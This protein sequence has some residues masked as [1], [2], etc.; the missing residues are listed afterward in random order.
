MVKVL[1]PTLANTVGLTYGIGDKEGFFGR[2]E[3]G[4]DY[5]TN[6]RPFCRQ[7]RFFQRE[8]ANL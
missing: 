2:S 5:L 3:I 8:D 6:S 1:K 7:T 4:A